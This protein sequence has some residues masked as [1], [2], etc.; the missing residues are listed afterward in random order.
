MQATKKV[1]FMLYI[2]SCVLVYQN[3]KLTWSFVSNFPRLI[4]NI[5]FLVLGCLGK[6]HLFYYNEDNVLADWKHSGA[7]WFLPVY[8]PFRLF[9]T[10]LFISTT[11][12]VPLG[13]FKIFRYIIKQNSK[14]LGLS[15][16]AITSRKQTNLVNIK[17]NLF[18]WILDT[19]SVVLVLVSG[20]SF[21]I[22]YLLVISCGPPL[23]YFLGIQE[24]RQNTRNFVQSRIRVF[25]KA[26]KHLNRIH[27]CL[28]TCLH[29]ILVR[30]ACVRC[31]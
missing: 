18:N 5:N 6:S 21:T 9:N 3:L 11:F 25:E 4:R 31:H 27:T 20:D 12:L 24:N 26:G 7:V 14:E 22:V 19:S 8:H 1:S 10:F 30:A 15:K 17:F 29:N 13:Y 28:Y 16:R 2:V 23:L